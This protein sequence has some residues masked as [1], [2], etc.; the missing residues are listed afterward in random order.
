VPQASSAY[1]LVL[2]HKLVQAGWLE[3]T[4]FQG[5]PLHEFELAL[6]QPAAVSYW[7]A[8]HFHG[9][10]EQIPRECCVLTTQGANVPETRAS[11]GLVLAGMH[12]RFCVVKPAFYFGTTTHWL[13]EI[14]VTVTDPERTLL[15]GLLRPQLCGDFD[16]VYEAFHAH[17]SHL[18]R[19]K[20]R[21]LLPMFTEQ[22]PATVGLGSR[23]AGMSGSGVGRRAEAQVTVRWTQRGRGRAR[24]IPVGRSSRICR[25]A[26]ARESDTASQALAAVA[27]RTPGSA[28]SSACFTCS[29]C[30]R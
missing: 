24:V 22:L 2:L 6:V 1:V 25:D 5:P 15:D 17:L 13:G 29:G 14:P 19:A 11:G 23:A 28:E 27:T 12:Y 3:P 21:G 7:S 4:V 20:I 8:L 26:L 9:L 30:F 16:V 18:E 10:T